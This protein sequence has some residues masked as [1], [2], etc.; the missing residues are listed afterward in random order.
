MPIFSA[1]MEEKLIINGL[2]FKPYIREEEIKKKTTEI[3]RKLHDELKGRD[4]MFICV[5]NGAFVFAADLIR[6]TGLN[7]SSVAFVRYKSYEGM[8]SSGKVKQLI[9]LTTDIENRDIVIVEDIVDTGFTAV[10]MMKDLKAL[11]PKSIRFVSLLN[12][13]E[14]SKTGFEP[15]YTAF[16]IPSKFIIGYG[17]DLDGK[18]RNLK[19]IYIHE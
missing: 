17:L 13:K 18:G 14:N 4:P 5:L 10:K 11:K 9:G 2:S 1:D 12:K 3:A 6:E 19:D 16:E 7:D 8:E 15:D